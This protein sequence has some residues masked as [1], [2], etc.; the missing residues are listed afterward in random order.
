VRVTTLFQ[1]KRERERERERELTTGGW[2]TG[3][4]LDVPD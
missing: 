1:A 3:G 2:E 4:L